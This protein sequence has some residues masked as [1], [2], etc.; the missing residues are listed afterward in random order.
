MRTRK[1]FREGLNQPSMKLTD[2][3]IVEFA[4]RTPGALGYVSADPVG[5]NIIQK[6]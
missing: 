6:F 1:A 2:N 4:K 3:E 5:V